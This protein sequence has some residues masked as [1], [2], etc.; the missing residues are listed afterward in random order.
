MALPPGSFQFPAGFRTVNPVPVDYWSGPFTG[1]TVSAAL[2]AANESIPVS[3][4]FR[5]LEVRIIVGSD[6]YKYWYYGGT[7]D[8]DLIEFISTVV[9]PTGNTG[10]DGPVGATGFTG[11]GFTAAF[12]SGDGELYISTLFPDG[13][14][15]NERSIGLVRGSDGINGERGETGATGTFTG[16]FVSTLNSLTGDITIVAGT[17]VGVEVD[18]STITISASGGSAETTWGRTDPTT[19]TVGGVAAGTTFDVSTSAVEVLHQMLYPYVSVA[20][21][22]FNSGLNT[23][24]EIGQTAGGAASTLWTRSGSNSNWVASSA[25]IRYTGLATGTALTAGNPLANGASVTYPAVRGTSI[26]S[27]MTV[28]LTAQQSGGNPIVTAPSRTSTWWSN[29]YFGKSSNPD[30]RTQSFDVTGSN[31]PSLVN[32]S[33]TQGPVSFDANVGAGD[34]YFYLFIH[35]YYTLNNSPP[36]FGL[37]YSG[38]PL[39]QDGLTSVTLTNAQGLTATYKRYKSLNRLNDSITIEVNPSS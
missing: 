6:T 11:Y 34:G 4:R 27:S 18:G 5:S 39:A 36:Y 15:G 26:G 3:A 12:V 16:N 37:K 13:S 21:I 35:D 22:S 17:N 25:F 23:Q 1:D 9:G 31:S 2:T 19:V 8:S 14:S 10:N 30:L 29:M 38:F 20:F 33:L 7:A 28:S 32:T 24:Y